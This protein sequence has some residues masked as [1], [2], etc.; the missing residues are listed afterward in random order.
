MVWNDEHDL[1]LVREILLQQ[2]WKQK[3]GTPERG[4]VWESIA[5]VLNAIDEPRFT[6][7]QRPVRDRYR[8]LE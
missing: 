1:L 8:L 6:V 5:D 3:Y 2:P 4:K 7:S